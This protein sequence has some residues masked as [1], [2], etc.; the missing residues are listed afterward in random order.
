MKNLNARPED[1][2]LSR[3]TYPYDGN[4]I[5]SLKYINKNDIDSLP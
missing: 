2:Y 1:V 5:P 3:N 4:L